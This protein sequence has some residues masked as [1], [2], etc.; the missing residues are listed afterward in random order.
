VG[1]HS[2]MRVIRVALGRIYASGK[3]VENTL[4]GQNV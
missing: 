3:E 4:E 1:E 2:K